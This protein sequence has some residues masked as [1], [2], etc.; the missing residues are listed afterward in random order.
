MAVLL[1]VTVPGCPC[2]S[3]PFH[4]VGLQLPPLPRWPDTGRIWCKRANFGDYDQTEEA[5]P[6]SSWNALWDVF[7]D[8]FLTPSNFCVCVQFRNLLEHVMRLGTGHNFVKENQTLG[9]FGRCF[10][11]IA[12][13]YLCY[14]NVGNSY[15]TVCDNSVWWWTCILVPAFFGHVQKTPDDFQ[16]L[17]TQRWGNCA[18]GIS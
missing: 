18:E 10:L 3:Q 17:S 9:W 4:K 12:S 15:S 13:P 8:S 6:G 2:P 7:Q 11:S 1:A 5:L 14:I 16:T